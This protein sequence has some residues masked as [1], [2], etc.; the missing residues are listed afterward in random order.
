MPRAAQNSVGRRLLGTGTNEQGDVEEL[1]EFAVDCSPDLKKSALYRALQASD[2]FGPRELLY[3]LNQKGQ[4]WLRRRS[5]K[6]RG[7]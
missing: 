3:M 1:V 6:Y 4:W 5:W 2:R 7:V